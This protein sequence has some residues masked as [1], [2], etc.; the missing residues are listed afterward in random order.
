M[1]EIHF[2]SLVK[3]KKQLINSGVK[4]SKIFN[5]GEIGLSYLDRAKYIGKREL[6]KSINFN[7]K[8]YNFLFTYHPNTKNFN[9]NLIELKIILKSLNFFKDVGF[10]FTYSNSDSGNQLV[11][12]QISK[13]VK[14]KDNCMILKYLGDM[15]Y[16]SLLKYVT[17][18][19]G[20]S[21]SGIW[22]VPSFNIPTLNLGERQTGRF[23]PKSVIDCKINEKIIKNKIKL[24]MKISS[25]NKKLPNP[26]YKKNTVDKINKVI[27]HLFKSNI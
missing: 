21:S 20:N 14:K 18:V 11:N 17:G 9:K 3:Y 15:S 23:K 7:L 2:T 25:K 4:K 26:Y 10:I 16:R 24:M 19:I 22:E 8:K 27:T 13:Y 6:E 1:S 12:S 5:V